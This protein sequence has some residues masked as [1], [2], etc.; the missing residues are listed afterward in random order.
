MTTREPRRA[1]TTAR[2]GAHLEVHPGAPTSGAPR[3]IRKLLVANR[4]EIACRVLRTCR[5]MGIATVAVF[6]EADALARHVAEADE[7]VCIGPSVASASYLNVPALI[8]A[9]ERTGADALHPGYGFLS[10]H[11]PFALACRAAG[12]TF[13]GPEPEVIARMGSKREARRLMAA[14]GVP[15]VPGY[16]EEDQSDE[17]CATPPNTSA[18]RSWSKPRRAAVARECAS[19]ERRKT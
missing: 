18:T 15:V 8:A 11:A 19:S 3:V 2:P 16:D 10:E 13:I 12:V 17:R 14:A 1:A 6:S 7:A 5:A 9:A 4:G